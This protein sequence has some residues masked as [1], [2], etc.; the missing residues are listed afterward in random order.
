MVGCQNMSGEMALVAVSVP[1]PEN[2]QPIEVG[3]GATGSFVT[4][5]PAS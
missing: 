4:E 5:L 1:R 3:F 2:V